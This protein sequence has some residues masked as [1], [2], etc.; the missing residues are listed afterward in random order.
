M[1][2]LKYFI[3]K[4]NLVTGE[5]NSQFLSYLENT[6]DSTSTSAKMDNGVLV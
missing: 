5:E 2:L 6:E 1:Q 4:K 3:M